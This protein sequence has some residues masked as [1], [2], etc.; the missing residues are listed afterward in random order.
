MTEDAQTLDCTYNTV[1]L[2]YM[3][4][5]PFVKGGGLF[6]RTNHTQ[7]LGQKVI[8]KVTLLTDEPILV[9][10]TV[11]WITPRGAQGNKHPGIGVEFSGENSRLVLNK[12]E[13]HLAGMLKSTQPTDTF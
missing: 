13:T 2:L 1:A 9:E 4:Y 12:I 3:A 8:L 10:G 7:P 6:I 11:V 5:M